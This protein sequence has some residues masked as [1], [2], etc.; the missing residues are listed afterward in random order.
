MTSAGESVAESKV[1]EAAARKTVPSGRAG[2]RQTRANR[3]PAGRFSTTQVKPGAA[4]NTRTNEEDV[5]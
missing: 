3:A 2:S 1:V 5:T 4:N